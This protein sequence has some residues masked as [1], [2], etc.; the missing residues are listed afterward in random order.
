MSWPPSRSIGRLTN[1]N[2]LVAT[3]AVAA[4]LLRPIHQ[5]RSFSPTLNQQWGGLQRRLCLIPRWRKQTIEILVCIYL[6]PSNPSPLRVQLLHTWGGDLINPSAIAMSSRNVHNKSTILVVFVGIT[7]LEPPIHR[8]LL[9]D[10]NIGLG[11]PRTYPRP[12]K[13]W[14]LSCVIHHLGFLV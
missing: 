14:D 9:V 10:A 8:S 1:A 6:P 12:N 7:S 11:P 5:M 4:D 2:G 13:W 3:L